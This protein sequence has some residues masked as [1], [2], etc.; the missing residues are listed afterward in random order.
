[1]LLVFLHPNLLHTGFGAPSGL[2]AVFFLHNGA[3]SAATEGVMATADNCRLK[4][5]LQQAPSSESFR[6]EYWMRS[7]NLFWLHYFD[8][9]AAMSTSELYRPSNRRLSVKL[10]PTFADRVLSR[11]QHGGS[12]MAVFL[13]F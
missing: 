10:V 11:S 8:P 9:S 5:V 4:R 12:P 6:F 1:L 2:V 3:C 7:P 13:V